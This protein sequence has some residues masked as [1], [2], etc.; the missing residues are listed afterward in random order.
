M[1]ERLVDQDARD[2]IRGNLDA[3]LIVEAA[4]G[5]GKTT[6]MIE[7]IITVLRSGMA[8]S[9]VVPL[10]LA[11]DTV[12]IVIME[13]VDNALM[14]VIPGAM[15]AGLDSPRFWLSLAFALVIAGARS[16]TRV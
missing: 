6:E 16:R 8:L 5:T 12:S 15:D 7:R 14:L 4:A 10:A 2:T 3:T 1:T 9:A 11:S 13:I